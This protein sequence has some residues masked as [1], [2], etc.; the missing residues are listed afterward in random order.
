MIL[1]M[2]FTMLCKARQSKNEIVQIYAERLYALA[3]D[4]FAKVD[5]VVE[6]RLVSLLMGYTMTS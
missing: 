5:K 6:S 2:L 4:A 3:N 1:T